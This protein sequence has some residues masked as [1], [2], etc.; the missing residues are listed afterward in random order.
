MSRARAERSQVIR[1]PTNTREVSGT[2]SSRPRALS[3]KF[4]LRHCFV[5]EPNDLSV[6][7]ISGASLERVSETMYTLN[8]CAKISSFDK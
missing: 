8:Y 6:A 7:N 2:L 1:P 4:L 5:S 3:R